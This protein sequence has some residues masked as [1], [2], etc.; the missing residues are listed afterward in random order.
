M[1]D[2]TGDDAG[3][4]A[5]VQAWTPALHEPDR[6]TADTHTEPQA[7]GENRGDPAY[8]GGY[9]VLSSYRRPQGVLENQRQSQHYNFE[10]ESTV[11]VRLERFRRE[12]QSSCDQ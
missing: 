6:A 12:Q 10:V 9:C 8:S 4:D 7:Q 1:C 11:T 3:V 2:N 5:V